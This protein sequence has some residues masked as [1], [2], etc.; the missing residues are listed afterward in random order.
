MASPPSAG[1][2]RTS[3][4]ASVD[5]PAPLGPTSATRRPGDSVRSTPRSAARPAPGYEAHTERSS[6]VC[7]PDP[8]GTGW[9][10][11][12]TTDGVSMAANTRPAATR[13]R[14][15]AWVAA[16]RGETTSTAA[17]GTRTNTARNAPFRDPPCVAR[18]PRVSAPQLARPIN[19]VVR[20]SPT[21]AV[22]AP[23][24]DSERRRLSARSIRP[25]C[26]SVP[27]ITISS[28]A[29]STMSTTSADSSP[30]TVACLASARV[31]RWP[32]SHG[33]AVAESAKRDEQH[34]AGLRE[35]PPHAGDRDDSDE[36]GHRKG[37]D[38]P[39]HDVLEGVH[40][41]DDPRHEVAAA[42]EREAGR[43]RRFE[44]FVDADA[45]VGQHPQA[46]RRGRRAARRSAGSRARARRTGRRRWRASARPRPGA[47]RLARSAR[48][49]SP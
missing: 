33:T 31:A 15:R 18:T 27:P 4:S 20:A 17:S 11:S 39:Q 41:V 10:G 8:T 9:S 7:G 48:P 30:R 43:R 24:R 29:P 38:H 16:G 12:V 25:S 3:T 32:V 42:E 26:A 28:G 13:E 19:S 37:L 1:R 14:C 35:D 21:P 2:K 45:Q 36:R 22:P 46:R 6:T 47:E 34:E 23:R 44:A 5:L 49:T 40:V